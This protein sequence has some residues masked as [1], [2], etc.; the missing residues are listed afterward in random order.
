MPDESV[1]HETEG[2]PELIC[3]FETTSGEKMGLYKIE[4]TGALSEESA[5]FIAEQ[6]EIVSEGLVTAE[7]VREQL[8]AATYELYFTI[9]RSG[10]MTS[11]AT[12]FPNELDP[13]AGYLNKIQVSKK[14]RGKGLATKL[15]D[16]VMADKNRIVLINIVNDSEV[17]V[18]MENLYKRNGFETDD[19]ISFSWTKD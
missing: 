4:D 8:S 13:K 18:A 2:L 11:F 19:N 6:K 16:Q 12:L 14:H 9:D 10:D 3:E 7:H 1:K 5:A 17:K 15:L